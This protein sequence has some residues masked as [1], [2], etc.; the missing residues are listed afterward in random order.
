MLQ[1]Y[2]FPISYAFLT[3]PIAALLFTLPFLIVQY[4]R[5]GYIN[6]VRAF[7][8]YLFLLYLMNAFYLILLPF[9]ASR[10]NAAPTGGSLQL[11]PLNFVQ[12]IISETQV[13]LTS[14]S[15]YLLLLKERASLQVLFNVVL[16]VP[17]G[18]FLRYYF[19]TGWIR[20]II[21]SFSLSLFFEITQLTGIYGFYDHPYRLADVDDLITNTLGGIVGFLFAEWISRLLPRMDRL[22]ANLDKTT[23]RVTYTRRGIALLIDLFLWVILYTLFRVISIP[24]A[25]FISTGLYFML[26]PYV[27]KGRTIGKWLVRIHLTRSDGRLTLPSLIYRYGLLYWVLGQLS[28]FRMGTL[29]FEKLP[30]LLALPLYFLIFL[31]NLAF[32]VH[33]VS[34]IF[35]RDYQLFYEKWSRTSHEITWPEKKV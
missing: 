28:V 35:K 15:S 33:L 31:V 13:K 30:S 17:F 4:R 18:I 11:I 19:R 25:Y 34:R 21:L 3:F 20:C 24:A 27:F 12:D 9:P 10:H 1:S 23:K 2:L 22:D 32:F 29:H 14:F 6:K 7:M 8:L 16:T 5:H 26:L